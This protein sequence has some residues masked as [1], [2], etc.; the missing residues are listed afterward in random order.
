VREVQNKKGSLPKINQ[1]KLEPE[2]NKLGKISQVI[3][4]NQPVLVQVIKEPIST[5]GPRLSC[6][7]SLAGRYLVL[8]PFANAVNIS[9]KITSK[10][11]RSRLQRL[12]SSI[13]PPNYGV[14][15]RTVAEGKDVAELDRDLRSLI[16][17][18][19]AGMETLRFAQPREKIIGELGRASAL[20]RDLL[21][22]SFDSI[23]VDDRA[24]YDEIKSYIKQV[25]PDKERI[26]KLHN[27][28]VKLFESL[29]IEKQLKSL[30]G[31]SV[32]LNH[33]GYLIIEHT[34]ALHVI[35]VNSGNKSNAEEDQEA[36]AINVNLDA[37]KEIARQLRIRDMGGIIIIDFI[38]MRKAE[39][40]RKVYEAMKDE[41][42]R[43]RSRSTVL[44]LTKFGLMQITRQRVRPELNI[45]TREVCP[46]CN[47]S[48]TV[49]ASIL[50][51]DLLEANVD[52]LLKKQN[53]KSLHISLHPYLYAYFTK[54]DIFRFSRRVKWLFK[55][56]RWI[57]MQPDS[58][59]PLMEFKFTNK[60]GEEIQLNANT[61][62]PTTDV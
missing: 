9:K 52:Y 2:I 34:E 21:N 25:A 62:T 16:D 55:Y 30:F 37:V 40:K 22:E 38:D 1:F 53:E 13:K 20:V 18:W 12:L 8:V 56:G 48:G 45:M 57:K 14:I 5:K 42:K 19:E 17:R 59:L 24:M 43:D 15:V 61:K 6:E 27:G 39:H 49:S 3:Q 41:M 58:S 11:E 23:S 44:P 31:K 32:S 35:D 10:E 47:G 60:A 54:G 46:S 28:K 29:G 7:I 33:G 4:R 51:A 50:V 26:V 36:T